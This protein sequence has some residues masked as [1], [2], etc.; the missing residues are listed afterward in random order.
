MVLFEIASEWNL[1]RC[2]AGNADEREWHL[3]AHAT[4]VRQQREGRKIIDCCFKSSVSCPP[5]SPLCVETRTR[6]KIAH[7]P[8]LQMLLQLH[9]RYK[10]GREGWHLMAHATRVRQQREKI[11]NILLTFLP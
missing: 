5:R 10:R 1:S 2:L 3:M 9:P 6:D 8:A 7:S 11:E 4:R